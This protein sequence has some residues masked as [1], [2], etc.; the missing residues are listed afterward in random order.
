MMEEYEQNHLSNTTADDELIRLVTSNADASSQYVVFRN[1]EDELFAINV[2]KVEELIVYKDLTIAKNSDPYATSVG[3]CKIRD[4]MVTIVKFDRWLGKAELEDEA[5]ELVMLCNYGQNRIGLV[6]KNVVGIMNIDSQKLFDNSEKDEKTSYITE[7]NIQN[8]D[9][10]CLIFDSDKLLVDIFPNIEE[11]NIDTIDNTMPSTSITKKILCAEDSKIVQRVLVSLLDRME[12]DYKIY[13]NGEELLNGMR[14][15]DVDDI[16]LIVTDIEMP[17]KDGLRV[18][19]ECKND[20]DYKFIPIIVNT[21]MANSAIAT[22]ATDLGAEFIIHKLDVDEL[23]K[24][25]NKYAR[26]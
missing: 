23:E 15:Y 7:I 1:G 4:N 19:S 9:Q 16:A 24:A 14:N 26:K 8:K 5:Y 20:P 22:K 6:I 10:L 17:K 11:K 2:A 21:N 25:I 3:T 12:L 18:L 13:N